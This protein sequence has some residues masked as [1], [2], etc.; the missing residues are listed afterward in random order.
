MVERQPHTGG[1]RG[2]AHGH[3]WRTGISVE[4]EKEG[5]F[6]VQ[7]LHNGREQLSVKEGKRLTPMGLDRF[8]HGPSLPAHEHGDRR[9]FRK[10]AP[11]RAVI[12]KE[13][14]KKLA[15]PPKLAQRLQNRL[16]QEV[17]QCT[18]RPRTARPFRPAT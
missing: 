7:H 11:P 12:P 15:A 4:Y 18:I 17:L 6:W 16:G 3:P 9:R 14:T 13:E 5:S 2:R 10:L 8:A 1:A